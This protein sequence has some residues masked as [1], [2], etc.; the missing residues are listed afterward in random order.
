MRTRLPRSQKKQRA[1]VFAGAGFS[2][3][4]GLPL[5]GELWKLGLEKNPE[6]DKTG[7][8]WD[9]VTKCKPFIDSVARDD[10]DVERLL[11]EW[12]A[13]VEENE[14][15]RPMPNSLDSGRGYRDHYVTNL[16]M[17]LEELTQ[18]VRS[19][20]VA[21]NLALQILNATKQ[22]ELSF[23]TTNYDRIIEHLLDMSGIPF[24]Y[25]SLSSNE[26]SIRKLHGSVNWMR[27]SRQ[28]R[29]LEDGWSPA[30][31]GIIE[32]ERIF[33]FQLEPIAW[34]GSAVPPAI[35][36]PVQ[37]KRYRGIYVRQFEDAEALIQN[38]DRILFV[39]YSFPAADRQ[40]AE[41][42]QKSVVNSR[43]SQYYFVS[44]DGAAL[45]RAQ[46]ILK[47]RHL[48]VIQKPFSPEHFEAFT[49]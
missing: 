14:R 48:S 20:A 28:A 39:G 22:M 49:A 16:T 43:C 24:N 5:T 27:F 12:E 17:H 6:A 29:R 25:T 40:L 44:P 21:R 42:I 30:E 7:L 38:A 10:G 36:P 18:R 47:G 4:F 19:Q 46:S 37:N 35:I 23:V 15:R 1:V 3:A 9:G 33:D 2:K 34:V 45:M 8:L 31:I 26:I 11:N 41:F 32:D 13:F